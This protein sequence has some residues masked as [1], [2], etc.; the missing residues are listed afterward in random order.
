MAATHPAPS[1]SESDYIEHARQRS[2][3]PDERDE[4]PAE[5]GERGVTAKET[6][7]CGMKWGQRLTAERRRAGRRIPQERTLRQGKMRRN[8]IEI[9]Y[10][11]DCYNSQALTWG[12]SD[13]YPKLS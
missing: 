5:G 4:A 13:E 1:L 12:F 7:G 10:V 6:R 9:E 8:R 3:N 2:L 11:S